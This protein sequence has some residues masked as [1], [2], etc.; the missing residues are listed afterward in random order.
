I[1]LKINLINKK[2]V[3]FLNLNHRVW[4]CAE[5]SSAF[6]GKKRTDSSMLKLFVIGVIS[7]D[8]INACY[9]QFGGS[10]QMG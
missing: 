8:I 6:K 10:S 2:S 9:G 4:L 3:L 1:T 7:R 5:S